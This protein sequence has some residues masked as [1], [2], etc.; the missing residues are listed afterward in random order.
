[1]LTDRCQTLLIMLFDHVPC[2]PIPHPPDDIGNNRL[3]DHSLHPQFL[4]LRLQ[5]EVWEC[6]RQ[7]IEPSSKQRCPADSAAAA[8]S[9]QRLGFNFRSSSASATSNFATRLCLLLWRG[10]G[11]GSSAGKIQDKKCDKIF[12]R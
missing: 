12:S 9:F 1:M 5:W 6:R 7:H 4:P 10:G 8:D 2:P 3:L 11:H